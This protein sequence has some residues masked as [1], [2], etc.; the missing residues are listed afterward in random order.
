MWRHALTAIVAFGLIW[1][2]IDSLARGQTATGIVFVAIAVLRLV[3]LVWNGK[4]RKPQ[5]SIRLN[6]DNDPAR[7][8]DPEEHQRPSG[9]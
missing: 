9:S 6:L 8:D 3:S 4:P 7:S 2:G 1:G 5:P